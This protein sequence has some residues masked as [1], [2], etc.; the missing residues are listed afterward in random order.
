MPI[1][2]GNFTVA[3]CYQGITDALAGKVVSNLVMQR[4]IQ[5]TTWELSGSYGM[6]GLQ[7]NGPF[8]RLQAAN[9]QYSPSFF[10]LPADATLDLRMVNSFFMYYDQ[11]ISN[12]P[13]FLLGAANAGV[14]LKYR[15]INTLEN[16]MN[17]TSI[18]NYW[19]RHNGI[20]YVAPV[21]QYS[22]LCYM[23][24]QHEHPFS[25]PV[26]DGDVMFFDDDWQDIVEYAAAMRI[27]WNTRLLDIYGNMRTM[28]YGDPKAV[29]A[30]G[31]RIDLGLIYSRTNQY[32]RDSTTS[33]RSLQK[34]SY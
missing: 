18:P 21:P 19:T 30:G 33:M 24:Y 8:V 26:A 13:P 9:S 2:Y 22:Y 6:Q 17:I 5:R 23:R 4:A 7:R 25:D 3:D 14:Q 15:S 1:G 10:M 12:P 29:D 31:R 20:I 11:A 28:L 32:E 16:T 27:A 34:R